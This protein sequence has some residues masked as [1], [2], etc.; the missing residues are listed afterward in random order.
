MHYVKEFHI[1][2]VAT[3]QVACI[4]LHGKPNAATEGAVGV[5]GVDMDSPLHEVYKCVGVNG[6]IYSW[7]LL[8]SGLSI[9]SA[10]ITGGGTEFVQFPYVNLLTP[11]MYV[12]KIGDLILDSEGYLY[13]IQALNTTYCDTKYTGTQVAAYGFSAYDLAVKNGFE[14]DE[15]EWLAS[16]QG[17]RGIQGKEGIQGEPGDT[18]YIG[19][20]GNWWIAGIDTGVHA[21]MGMRMETVEYEGTGTYGIDSPTVVQFSFMPKLVIVLGN[22]MKNTG[23]RNSNGIQLYN[24]YRNLFMIFPEARIYST[25]WHEHTYASST[26]PVTKSRNLGFSDIIDDPTVTGMRI[27]RETNT[28]YFAVST[29]GYNDL[30]QLNYKPKTYYDT[31]TNDISNYRWIAIG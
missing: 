24:Y 8:S 23:W 9:M 6:S 17:E 22:V 7:E 31:S 20:N 10:T 30:H 11:A 5:L 29:S 4:E 1:N 13:Q 14:G 16:L 21:D 28:F 26:S 25:D 15:N 18:P 2:G 12:V 27:D 3:K 19:E